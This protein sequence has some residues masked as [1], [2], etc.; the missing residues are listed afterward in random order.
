MYE[1]LGHADRFNY[2][3]YSFYDRQNLNSDAR[4]SVSLNSLLPETEN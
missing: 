1:P 4:H 2:L 3:Y